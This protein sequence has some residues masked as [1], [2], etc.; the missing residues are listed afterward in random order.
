LIDGAV[1]ES[2]EIDQFLFRFILGLG[3]VSDAGADEGPDRFVDGGEPALF[4]EDFNYVHAG[5][6]GVGSDKEKR[7]RETGLIDWKKN[8]CPG[9]RRRR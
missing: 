9:R 3:R 2:A 8:D 5:S 4:G 7:H 6:D 1:G